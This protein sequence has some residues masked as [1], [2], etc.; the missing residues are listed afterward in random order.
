MPTYFIHLENALKRANGEF[1]VVMPLILYFNYIL[2]L[3]FI[4]VSNK[5]RA[6][7]ILCDVL[8]SKKHRT[9]QKKHEEIM[10]KYLELCVELK[11]SYVAKEGIYQYK[12]ICQQSYIGSFEDVIRKYIA[13]AEEKA[14]QAKEESQANISE[15]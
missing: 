1:N 14:N 10:M 3:E 4:E 13:M 5:N 7:E 8:H 2:I 11:Q 12:I 6:L 9:W 15:I